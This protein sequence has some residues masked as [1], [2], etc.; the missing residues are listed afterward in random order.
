MP[1][2]QPPSKPYFLTIGRPCHAT[3]PAD[4]CV[5]LAGLYGAVTASRKILLV[6]AIP[7][8]VGLALNGCGPARALVAEVEQ[9][10]RE[11]GCSELASDAALWNAAAQ[12]VHRALGFE[13][14]ER[15]V[16]FRRTIRVRD[17]QA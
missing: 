8:A 14:T 3:N 15:V 17:P 13:E 4:R 10:A 5:L 12:A 9:W 11:Q 2:S 6:Q 16:Y 7:A 1:D